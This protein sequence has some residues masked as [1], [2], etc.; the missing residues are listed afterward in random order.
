Q[1][2]LSDMTP[3]ELTF[4]HKIESMMSAIDH[5]EYRQVLV[6]LLCIIAVILERNRELI[7]SDKLDLDELISTAFRQYCS[8]HEV[9]DKDDMTPFY[10]L[11]DSDL[12]KNST[13]N[14]FARAVIDSLLNGIYVNRR[15]MTTFM[16]SDPLAC[17][18]VSESERS[19]NQGYN[20]CLKILERVILLGKVNML[21]FCI[22]AFIWLKNAAKLYVII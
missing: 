17:M 10:E 8:D 6:E 3:F 16:P 11:D 1:P 18:A 14:Y 7:F 9:V 22:Y 12:T 19:D 13:A 4:S 20:S 2:T 15:K 21:L 5:P